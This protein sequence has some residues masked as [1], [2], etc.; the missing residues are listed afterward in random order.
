MPEYSFSQ[1]MTSQT[2]MAVNLGPLVDMAA[3]RTRASLN[4][5]QVVSE[6]IQMFPCCISIKIIKRLFCGILFT[7]CL[8]TTRQCI[9][10]ECGIPLI[11]L[12]I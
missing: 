1:V 10:G 5:R 9:L 2:A 3:L 6:E 8:Y 11:I 7:H 4:D 12:N